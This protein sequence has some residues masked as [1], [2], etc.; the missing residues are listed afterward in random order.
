[1]KIYTKTGDTGTTSL[2]GGEITE[3]HSLRVDAYGTLDEL[4]ASVG[5]ARA[6][7]EVSE[8]RQALKEIER[9]LILLMTE[10]S[11]S[12]LYGSHDKRR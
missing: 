1:M 12:K 5:F 11:S 9:Q 3:K 6:L 10:V 8:V 7:C 4:Q 2:Y